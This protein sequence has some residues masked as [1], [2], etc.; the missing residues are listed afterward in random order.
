EIEIVSEHHIGQTIVTEAKNRNLNPAKEN[1]LAAEAIKGKGVSGALGNDRY[2][3][4]NKK[5]MDDNDIAISRDVRE[6]DGREQ[7]EGNTAIFVA[8]N[9]SLTGI[10]SIMDKI[11]NDA[12]ATIQAFRNKGVKNLVMLT[13]DNRY[14]AER[15][16]GILG[17]DGFHAEL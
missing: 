3:I 1:V 9:G 15:V 5:L 12:A 17:L 11:R 6:R 4:G 14:A 2:L 13:G 7:K 10:V 8:K 16:R